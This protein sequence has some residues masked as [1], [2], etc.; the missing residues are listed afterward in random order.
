MSFGLGL[1]CGLGLALLAWMGGYLPRGD[2]GQPGLPSGRD[3]PAILEAPGESERGTRDSRYDFFTVLPEIE[4]VVPNREIEERARENPDQPATAAG[5]SYLIQ[6]GSFRNAED[7]EALKA[8]L[9]LLGLT[10]RIQTVTVDGQT[11]HRIRL[12]P[13]ETARDANSAR[14]TLG[15][16]GFES[17]VLS[18]G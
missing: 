14:R 6:A 8:R 9:A 11:W 18:D 10:A 3:E 4:V 17:I 16:N 7:A 13:Y 12:G 2:D 5:G 15:E 1:A